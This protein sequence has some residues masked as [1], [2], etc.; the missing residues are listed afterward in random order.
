MVDLAFRKL[1]MHSSASDKNHCGHLVTCG[2]QNPIQKTVPYQ[3]ISSDDNISGLFDE[4]MITSWNTK[5]GKTNFILKFHKSVSFSQYRIFSSYEDPKKAPQRWTLSGSNDGKDFFVL[6]KK[7]YSAEGIVILP[8]YYLTKQPILKADAEQSFTYLKFEADLPADGGEDVMIGELDLIDC[9]DNS[10][11]HTQDD[12]FDPYWQSAGNG[13]EWLL[14]DLGETAKVDQTEIVFS[15]KNYATAYTL[16]YSEDGENWLIYEDV[17]NA[18]GA[19]ALRKKSVFARYLKL[20]L[21]QAA[22][23]YYCVKEWHVL[24]EKK[25]EVTHD[26]KPFPFEQAEWKLQRAT[27]VLVDGNMISTLNYV[28]SNWMKATVPGV[29]LTSFINN[30]AV[31]EYNYDENAYQLSDDYFNASWWY[32]C[33][34]TAPEGKHVFLTFNGVNRAADFYLNGQ[35]IGSSPS[36]FQRAEFEVTH[37]L[38]E[39]NCLAVK[40]KPNRHPGPQ[41]RYPFKG[42]YVANGGATGLDEPCLASTVGWDWIPTVAGRNVGIYG[43]T[44]LSIH[45][46]IKIEN[47]YFETIELAP[48]QRSATLRVQADF[49]NLVNRDITA[50][51]TFSLSGTSLILAEEVKVRQ[52]ETLHW[53]AENVVL[54]NPKLWNPV[55]YGEAY[56]YHANLKVIGESVNTQTDFQ[57]GIRKFEYPLESNNTKDELFIICNGKRIFCMGGNWG[58]PDALYRTDRRRYDQMVRLHAQAGLNCIRNWVGQTDS[59]EFYD[60]CD[61]YG[62]MVWNDFWL[63]NPGDGPNPLNPDLFMET[64]RKYV[65]RI[66]NHPSLLLYC[67]RNEGM[68]SEP[69]KTLLPEMLEKLDPGRFYLPHSSRGIVSGEGP[70]C[71]EEPSFYFANTA[72][73]LHSERGVPNIPVYESIVRFLKPE[74]RWPISD[75][76]AYHGLYCNGAQRADK[77]LNLLEKYYGQPEGLREFADRAQMLNY[78]LLKAIF[79]AARANHSKGMLLWMS[80]SSLPSFVFQLYDYYLEQNGGYAGAKTASQ[81]ILAFYNPFEKTVMLD[82]FDGMQARVFCVSAEMWDVNGQKIYENRCSVQANPNSIQTL[83]TIPEF[84]QTAFLQLQVSDDIKIIS[85][86]FDVV[87]ANDLPLSE[88]K[89]AKIEVIINKETLCFRNCGQIPAVQIRFGFYKDKDFNENIFY[90]SDD[91]YFS[92]MPGE[93]RMTS[94]QVFEE[95]H[96]VCKVEGFNVRKQVF[97]I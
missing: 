45:D 81:P 40:V 60:A 66:R 54:N 28:D 71:A 3:I 1:V 38:K 8:Y 25:K 68:P 22:G 32:R 16:L 87:F 19:I 46:D 26:Y 12:S 51:V 24:G 30:G 21:H 77:Y 52:G 7:D 35:S 33:R 95:K 63:A 97:E 61:R 50:T 73:T 37:L 89:T 90:T 53:A 56:L 13:E 58:N 91:N 88:M 43:K 70:Y 41:K 65:M 59:E 10:I 74:N 94:Y 62:I 6:D 29:V 44:E 23:E 49:R 85:R 67:G 18:D 79:E 47:P 96:V 80:N 69:L 39:E 55:G 42:N 78:F 93:E 11:L 17:F 86:N 14:L 57:V 48:D 2:H 15:E 92:L 34:F 4:Q 82:C 75:A 84:E 5:V 27:D 76:W 83:F 36:A 64:A 31:C 72:T 9:D 20:A